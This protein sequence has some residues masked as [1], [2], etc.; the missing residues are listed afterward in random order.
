MPE[1]KTK[2]FTDQR[3]EARLDVSSVVL[4]FLGSRVEDYQP[5]QY[6]LKDVSPGGACI[7][8]PSWLTS[9]ERLN[10]GDAVNFHVPFLLDGKI[11]NTG[12]V[13]WERWSEEED[14][15]FVGASLVKS[16]VAEYPVYISLAAGRID[17]DLGEFTGLEDLLAMVARDSALLKKGV[18]IYLKHLVTYFSRAS[19][20]TREDYAFFREAI[21]EDVLAKVAMNAKRLGALYDQVRQAG[22]DREA[23]VAALDMEE[24]R[25]AIEPELYVDM[26]Q[27]AMGEKMVRLYLQAIKD[28]EKKL[29]SNYNT[30]VLLYIQTL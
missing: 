2:N 23:V 20:M 30:L 25:A 5:F 28:L 16:T 3:R 18:L 22:S 17:I 15:Q 24:I 9:R 6:L 4:P 21:L 29:Y 14:A 11:L 27:A 1:T 8:L 13:A 10:R 19:G 26:L 12:A 7:S